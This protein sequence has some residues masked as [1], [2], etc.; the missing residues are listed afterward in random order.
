MALVIQISKPPFGH[1]NTFAG[2]FVA[3][4][5]LSTGMETIVLLVG[6]G[7]YAAMKGQVNPKKNISMVPTE[8]QV[9]DIIDLGGR[10]LVDVNALY[11]RGIKNKELIDGLEVKNTLEIQDLILDYADKFAAF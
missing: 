2:L 6:N 11:N 4:A 5:S 7:V 9:Q 10:V 1:E 8:T 3:S